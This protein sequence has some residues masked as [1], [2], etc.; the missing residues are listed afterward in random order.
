[1]PDYW[2]M[3]QVWCMISNGAFCR[4]SLDQQL[5]HLDG[6][7]LSMQVQLYEDFA[8]SRVKKQVEEVITGEDEDKND[9]AMTMED[10]E[11][12]ITKKKKDASQTHIFQAS[13]RDWLGEI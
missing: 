13:Q 3:L 9:V 11:A 12:A 2:F 4:C 8:K 10:A 1:M 7:L 5:V 6:E